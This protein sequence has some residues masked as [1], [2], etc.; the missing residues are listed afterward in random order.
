M[1]NSFIVFDDEA[2]L[3][4][5]VS[6]GDKRASFMAC[7]RTLGKASP[8]FKKML[9]GSFSESKPATGD[10]VVHLPDEIIQAL[11]LVMHIIHLNFEDTQ[12]SGSM[13]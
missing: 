1:E 9:F 2:D 8:V 5:E 3:R 11:T 4:L 13:A 10:W 12:R 7:S 6:E